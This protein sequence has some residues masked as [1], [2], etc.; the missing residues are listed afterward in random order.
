MTPKQFIVFDGI[1]DRLGD[2]C[3]RWGEMQKKN[4]EIAGRLSEAAKGATGSSIRPKYQALC[5][6]MISERLAYAELVKGIHGIDREI[7]YIT[8]R[9]QRRERMKAE[10]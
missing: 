6:H 8:H 9:T 4:E 10:R 3:R 2:L 5:D 1:C 7:E